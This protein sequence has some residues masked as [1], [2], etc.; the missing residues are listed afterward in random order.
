MTTSSQRFSLVKRGI[1]LAV[2]VLGAILVVLSLT[3]FGTGASAVLN[4]VPQSASTPVS[5]PEPTTT[6]PTDTADPTEVAATTEPGASTPTITPSTPA[7]PVST[8]PLESSDATGEPAEALEGD[9]VPEPAPGSV[10]VAKPVD[11][12]SGDDPTATPGF[13]AMTPDEQANAREWLETQAITDEC[14]SEKGFD[15]YNYY[16]YW[17]HPEG[18]PMP[19]QWIFSIPKSERAAANLAEN[20][21]TGG[22][23]DYHWDD[24]GC[25]GYAVHMMGNDNKH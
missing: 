21:N 18:T 20:G 24:A 15:E 8:V 4:P 25:W 11:M 3:I 2:A 9:A 17:N 7:P 6:S 22:G 5:R 1:A 16:A 14:M 13:A 23:A 12:A 19:V 10:V